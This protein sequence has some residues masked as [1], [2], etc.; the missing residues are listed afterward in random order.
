MDLHSKKYMS[1]TKQDFMFMYQND[2]K[3]KLFL[4][5]NI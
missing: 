5:F 2:I 3:G 4:S 1:E